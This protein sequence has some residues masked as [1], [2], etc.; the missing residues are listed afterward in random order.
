MIDAGLFGLHFSAAHGRALT[1]AFTAS[2]PL[3]RW[4]CLVLSW[5]IALLTDS[6]RSPPL[7]FCLLAQ[8]GQ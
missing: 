5:L 3:G 6:I 1:S 7:S 2:Q 8:E 4:Y